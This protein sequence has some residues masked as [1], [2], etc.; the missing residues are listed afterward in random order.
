MKVEN[1][2]YRL[3]V[4]VGEDAMA[5]EERDAVVAETALEVVVTARVAVPGAAEPTETAAAEM[6]AEMAATAD[7]M[8]VDE[9]LAA[10]R[11]AVTK[12]KEAATYLQ[13]RSPSRPLRQ[14]AQT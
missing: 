7:M 5:K 13:S 3:A 10:A 8:V 6:A 1:E 4:Q 2:G 14:I 11:V 9:S 12:A